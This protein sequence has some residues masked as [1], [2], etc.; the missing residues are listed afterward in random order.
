VETTPGEVDYLEAEECTAQGAKCAGYPVSRIYWQKVATNYWKAET[1]GPETS[2]TADFLDWGDNLESRSWTTTSSIR[3]ETTPFEDHSTNPTPAV[4]RGY[5][6]WH[7]Y[8]QGPSEVWGVRAQAGDDTSPP[9]AVYY[10]DSP[11]A[12]INTGSAKLHMAKLGASSPS[13]PTTYTPSGFSGT[14]TYD[15]VKGQYT[16]GPGSCTLRDTGYTAELNVG[17]KYVYGY[18]WQIRNDR[19]NCGTDWVMPGW[20]RLTFYTPGVVVFDNAAIPTGPPT[21]P[22]AVPLTLSLLAEEEGDALYRPVI[23][24]VNN[25]TYLDI[26]IKSSGG[27]KK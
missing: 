21:L 23:D 19:L 9:T 15:P 11:Y 8:G 7:V 10:Y 16:W 14:W 1:T 4:K 24:T 6:M 12:I 13:C 20:W 25:L 26:C 22:P 2:V 17:G 27:G 3:V 5:Q 18:N